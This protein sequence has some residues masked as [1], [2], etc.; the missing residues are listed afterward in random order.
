M[1]N[2]FYI[3]MV[4]KSIISGLSDEIAGNIKIQINE[5][6]KEFLNN[7]FSG[8][9]A[10]TIKTEIDRMEK[11]ISG[12]EKKTRQIVDDSGKDIKKYIGD[13]RKDLKSNDDHS[14]FLKKEL[15]SMKQTLEETKR[16]QNELLNGIIEKQLTKR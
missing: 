2:G 3:D 10:G 12:I 16:E 6:I 1:N 14:A 9:I 13:I 8:L 7:E 11:E 15:A 4:S 5:F